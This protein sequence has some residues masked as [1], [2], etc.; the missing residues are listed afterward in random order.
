MKSNLEKISGLER[1]LN[2]EIPAATVEAAFEKLFKQVQKEAH[3]KGFRPG[4]VPLA[5]VKSM[6]ADRVKQDVV[7]DLI[8]KHY[9]EAL[10]EHSLDPINYP[11]FEFDVPK[12]GVDF[13]F[14]AHFEV[15]PDVALK[16]YEGLE[17]EKEKLQFDESQIEAVLTNIRSSRAE[18]VPVF[19]D[20]PARNGDFAVVDFDGFVDG[21]ALEG[22]KGIDHQL[23]LGSKSFI[24]GFEEGVVGM[25]VGG[26]KTLQLKFPDPYHAA[27]LAGKPVEF[28]VQLKALKRKDLPELTEDFLKSIG[29]PETLDKLKETIRQ[30]LEQNEVRR[31]DQDFKNRLLKILV[32]ENPVDVPPSML[33]D[34]KKAL[35]EDMK[36][37]MMDQGMPDK[38]FA[39]YV[40]KWD[41]DFAATAA[42]MIKAGFII[43]A[44]A[45]KHELR[46]SKADVDQKIQTYAQQANMD[47]EKVRE[48]YAKPEQAQRLTYMI[49]EEKVIEFLTKTVK[50]KEVEKSKLKDSAN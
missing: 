13:S 32:K 12:E 21:K 35:I 37:K 20:R 11:E 14:S 31:I 29:A 3:V 38:E 17:V 34:Q 27:E 6:Y 41:G 9:Y 44:I 46:W 43:D 50:I 39:D 49:T 47:V 28:K 26:N 4:K 8:Q 36:Q 30:D 25:S 1:K 23:E 15:R 19:E 33:K 7:Q 22:G 42:D 45:N 16:K 5:T 18:Y 40:N 24:D 2:V 48:F 10:K